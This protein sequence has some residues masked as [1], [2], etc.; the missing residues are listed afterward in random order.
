MVN[1]NCKLIINKTFDDKQISDIYIALNYSI[2]SIK[3]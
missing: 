2:Y 3:E 1:K